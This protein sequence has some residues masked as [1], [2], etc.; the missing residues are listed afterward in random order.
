MNNPT[1][2]GKDPQE[3][4][5][6][7]L[8][9]AKSP[10]EGKVRVEFGAR[11]DI[12]KKRPNNEDQFLIVRLTKSMEVLSSSLPEDDD[13]RLPD[14]VGYLM[15]V[16]DG[17]GGRAAGERASALAVQ[18][19]KHHLL[20]TAR[21]FF[22]LDDPDEAVR[23]R[24]LRE[25]LE[26]LDRKILEEGEGNAALAGM[27]TTL[28]VASSI[29]AE[30]FI[31][32]VGD[33][34]AYLFHEGELEQLTT[35]HTLAQH[36]VDAGL[37]GAEEAKSHRLRHVLTNVVGG[38]PGVKGEVQKLLL[39]DGDRLLLCTD[40]LTE[41]VDDDHIAKLLGSHP[42][43]EDA[44]RALVEAALERGGKDNVTVVVAA[45]SIED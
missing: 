15:L 10:D 39:V 29:G 25:A 45:Y 1:R 33:S 19:T 40:G 7:V 9:R 18:E 41:A 13:S 17:M 42:Q 4:T 37:L 28:T 43:P 12:G 31:V 38:V 5:T 21:W 6:E 27:G 2:S 35:D 3:R 36:M 20:Q 26:R 44:C 14:R 30:V 16:A 23:L 11:T 34:R 24:L 32:H 8:L 22:R